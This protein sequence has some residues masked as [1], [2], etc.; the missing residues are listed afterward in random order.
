MPEFREVYLLIAG[1]EALAGNR[2]ASYYQ[3]LAQELGVA[4]RCRWK[5]GFIADDVVGE[6]F[7]A[8][9]LVLLTYSR[10]FRSA[11]GVLNVA[12]ASRKSCIA[13]SGQGHLQSV[14]SKYSLGVW[15]EPDSDEAVRKG[16]AEWL[17]SPPTPAWTTYEEENGWS[18]AASLILDRLAHTAGRTT[19]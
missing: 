7:E 15:V 1:L 17:T 8:C 12:A 6:L 3:S 14:I 16:L 10:A 13:S 5:L 19:L 2:P 18:R 9:D 4:D 11:S